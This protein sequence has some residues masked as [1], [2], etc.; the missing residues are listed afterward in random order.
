MR[1]AIRCAFAHAVC[2]YIVFSGKLPRF[3][4]TFFRKVAV[5]DIVGT[6]SK[7]PHD[8]TA[9][10]KTGW[11]RRFLGKLFFQ[12]LAVAEH[13][14]EFIGSGLWN[15]PRHIS[16]NAYHPHLKLHRSFVRYF[17]FLLL[18]CCDKKLAGCQCSKPESYHTLMF[19]SKLYEA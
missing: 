13:H 7:A 8:N 10:F 6:R 5:S 11:F 18:R 19:F 4:D 3:N 14:N 17:T 15:I 9:R 16:A 12:T 2:D 1:L